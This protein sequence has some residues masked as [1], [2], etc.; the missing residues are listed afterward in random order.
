VPGK[1]V[2]V[3]LPIP[4]GGSYSYA[5]P[6]GMEI[7]PGDLVQVPLG[8]RLVAA[9]VWDGPAGE[10]DPAK[11][12]Q[13]EQRFDC[14][15]LDSDMRRF[16][17]WVAN[18]TLSPPGMV[19]RMV[20]R[21]PGAF[22]PPPP[23]EGI[24]FSGT[25]PERL[26]GARQRV[27]ELAREGG[28]WT[29]SGLAHAAGTSPG[30][31]DGLLKQGVFGTVQLPPPPIV[32]KPDPDHAHTQLTAE[33][34]QA[35]QALREAAACPGGKG[36]FSVTLLE[37]VTGSGKTEVYFE[38]VAQCLREGRQALILLPEIS[39][40]T[41]FLDRFEQRF[42]ARPAEWHSELAPRRRE[43]VWRQAATG[44]IRAIAGARSALFL[45]LK[46]AGLIVVD[47]E[48]DPAFKQE[49]RSIY[50]ARDMAVVRAH[51]GGFAVVLS[52]ATPSIETQVNARQGKYRHV[53]LTTRFADAQ[54]PGIAVIDMRRD[55]PPAGRFISGGLERAV[56][57]ALERKEQSLLFLNRRGYAPLTL[58]R[59]CGH[60]FEC[61]QC[62]AWLVEHRY[63]RQLQCH[64]CGHNQPTPEACPNCG[65]LDHL[66]ACGPGVERLAEEAATLWP[67]ARIVV[68]SSDLSGSVSRLR[69]ELE[70]I[71]RGEA[72]IVIGTQLVAKGHHFPLM[73]CVGVIDADLGLNNGD[74][75]AAERTFQLL[76]Q[77]TGRAGRSGGASS[78]FIQTW[79]PAHPVIQ[80]LASGDAEAF[81]ER[82]CAMRESAG[83][84][85]FGRLAAVIVSASSRTEAEGH[86]RAM[87]KAAP[88]HHS[89]HILGPAEAPMAMV[90]GR[91]RFRMLAQAGRRDDL[92]GYLRGWLAASPRE[93]GSIR[94]Q[95]DVDPQ[96]FL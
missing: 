60:R 14:P 52:S 59:V 85:P 88:A 10:V 5:V 6:D 72:D 70:A 22:D 86:A 62:S 23:V 65:T 49:E 73:T 21:V 11:L 80:A 68:L 95:V 41:A 55:Q 71:S 46:E 32:A 53:R 13:V 91:H 33:Q 43:Q 17:D 48:H 45:P 4:A 61:P 12:R 66:V 75:R 84:P 64:H 74:P 31:I 83:L 89:I 28:A 77:V 39:L 44:E 37:G 76:R 1:I 96:S 42:G 57:A 2:S 38:A 58:C 16:V 81:F 9:A 35:A 93:R 7:R 63:R 25:E 34:E 8:P 82:E 69:M 54:M 30:V 92:Q 51:I 18:Y 3:L 94:V 78:A 15:P 87:R 50:H 19:L 24:V 90:R 67:Q 56:G 47:E 20:L 27:L 40:T 36:D 79:Q 26:T 29:R